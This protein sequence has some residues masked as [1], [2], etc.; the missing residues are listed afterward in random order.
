MV[1]YRGKGLLSFLSPFGIRW[2]E[3]KC[4]SS[5][6]GKQMD[7]DPSSSHCSPPYFSLV[8]LIAPSF[9]TGPE[10]ARR[11]RSS[12]FSTSVGR[13]Q[14]PIFPISA[15][16]FS[17]PSLSLSGSLTPVVSVDAEGVRVLVAEELPHDDV[18]EGG[19]DLGQ[20][21]VGLVRQPV[22]GAGAALELARRSVSEEEDLPD[23]EGE[24]IVR[25]IVR[26]MDA[27]ASPSL[28][29]CIRGQNIMHASSFFFVLLAHPASLSRKASPIS[30]TPPRAPPLALRPTRRGVSFVVDIGRYPSLSVSRLP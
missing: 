4:A 2:E 7:L 10:K 9:P 30:C 3:E 23:V 13:C 24:D 19:H 26:V 16:A 27:R 6:M 28:Y 20:A 12:P 29:L 22:Y 17:F 8:R 21:T 1:K 11:V 15:F 25:R 18:G 5:D 14:Y